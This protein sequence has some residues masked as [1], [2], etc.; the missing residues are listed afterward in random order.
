MGWHCGV[1]PARSPGSC[2]IAHRA[3]T[4]LVRR[5]RKSAAWGL[6][7]NIAVV[8]T[9]IGV[10]LGLFAFPVTLANLRR[11]SSDRAAAE[12][13]RVREHIRLQQPRLHSLA[14]AAMDESW[15]VGDLPMITRPDWIFDVP[16]PL[17]SIDLTWCEADQFL[18]RSTEALDFVRKKL[19]PRRPDGS[20]FPT[21]SDALAEISS[22][23]HLYNGWVYRPIG[24]EVVDGACR[25]AFTEGHYFDHLNATEVLAYEAGVADMAGEQTIRNGAYRRFLRDPFDLARHAS[26]L[27][28]VT[29]TVRVGTSGCGFYMHQRD[30]QS[31]IAG[32]EVTHVI[33]AGEF[34]PADVGLESRQS[35]FNIWNT[36][37]RE[38]AEEFLDVEEAYGR[39]GRP[40]DYDADPPFDKIAAGYRDGTIRPHV[41]GIGLDCLTWKPELLLVCPIDAEVFDEIFGGMRTK[42]REGTIL[43]GPHGNGIPFN[44]QSIARYADSSSTRGAARACLRLAW[45]HRR[46]LGLVRR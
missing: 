31:V 23:A 13:R 18:D 22:M 15:Q 32:S 11:G 3:T 24:I 4:D 40:I 27:G 2:N 19:L 35:D 7:L 34:A 17:S 30:G 12:F 28:V 5:V 45:Q 10:L 41:V 26:S 33:P 14:L 44:E 43:V 20:K 46:V 21:Y 29:L 36:V 8:L 1:D 9:S 39:G 42:G 16:M 37:V 6:G 25:L 38:F